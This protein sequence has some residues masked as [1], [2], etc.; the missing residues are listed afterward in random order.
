MVSVVSTGERTMSNPVGSNEPVKTYVSVGDLPSKDTV[1]GMKS[2][3][4]VSSKPEGGALGE[5]KRINTLFKEALSGSIKVLVGKDVHLYSEIKAGFNAKIEGLTGFERFAAQVDAFVGKLPVFGRYISRAAAVMH[6]VSK[7]EANYQK[8]LQKFEQHD[9]KTINNITDGNV[10]ESCDLYGIEPSMPNGKI[11]LVLTKMHLIGM[12]VV[13]NRSELL[14]KYKNLDNQGG[15]SVL[16]QLV[17]DSKD[18][19]SGEQHLA[20]NF[21][22]N[23]NS[24]VDKSLEAVE[25]H[26]LH[27]NAPDGAEEQMKFAYEQIIAEKPS[28]SGFM[29]GVGVG[30]PGPSMKEM[31]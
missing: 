30:G 17:A 12:V 11:D 29:P 14:D 23:V 31:V 6:E 10:K 2:G 19:N 20:Q 7:A 4:S 8:I 27:K 5:L 13:I 24:V 28:S 22:K 21:L 1:S 3:K 25:H 16:K 18:A 26:N 15:L 9:L